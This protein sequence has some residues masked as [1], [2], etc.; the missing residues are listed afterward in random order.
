M[1]STTYIVNFVSSGL[2]NEPAPPLLSGATLALD[3]GAGTASL[4]GQNPGS[5]QQESYTGSSKAENASLEA[6]FD[7]R[8]GESM[9]EPLIFR[10]FPISETA[11]QLAVGVFFTPEAVAPSL[12]PDDVG[13]YVAVEPTAV[14]NSGA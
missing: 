1:P 14:P 2:E 6:T 10:L 8:N 9:D 13:S 5:R 11:D 7:E 3:T 12:P 4:L